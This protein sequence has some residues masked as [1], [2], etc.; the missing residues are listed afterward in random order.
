MGYVVGC[1]VRCLG[2]SWRF[3]GPPGVRAW[4]SRLVLE[5]FVVRDYVPQ[6]SRGEGNRSGTQGQGQ[7]TL[8]AGAQDGW[9]MIIP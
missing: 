4:I 8:A 6:G 2:T 7:K 3:L 5:G 1:D 9:S